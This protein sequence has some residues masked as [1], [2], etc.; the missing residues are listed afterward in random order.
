MWWLLVAR[1]W[2]AA[3]VCTDAIEGVHDKLM[4]LTKIIG[5]LHSRRPNSA[6]QP[7]MVGSLDGL[8]ALLAHC[9]D[10]AQQVALASQLV[11]A[12]D[13]LAALWKQAMCPMEAVLFSADNDDAQFDAH[14]LA[15]Q[16]LF[17]QMH[18]ALQ[19]VRNASRAVAG[20]EL[21]HAGHAEPQGAG[22][23]GDE[24]VEETRRARRKRR[25]IKPLEHAH[26]AKRARK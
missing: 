25:A 6:S 18:S 14:A 16:R 19:K 10:Q 13:D 4:E 3:T 1:V 8:R 23:D 15:A 26:A 20:A 21:L 24:F 5:G 9:A 7:S 17:S 11:C 2:G 12:K 22:S